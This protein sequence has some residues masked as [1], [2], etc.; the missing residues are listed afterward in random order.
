MNVLPI[1]RPALTRSEYRNGQLILTWLGQTGMISEAVRCSEAE[2]AEIVDAI[3][4]NGGHP[5]PETRA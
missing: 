2:S 1:A 5:L 3:Q 4:K